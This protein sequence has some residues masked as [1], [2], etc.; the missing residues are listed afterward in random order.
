MSWRTPDGQQSR[1]LRGFFT[2]GGKRQGDDL[3]LSC[4]LSLKYPE[5]YNGSPNH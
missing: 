3:S 4:V 2:E 5:L 1:F